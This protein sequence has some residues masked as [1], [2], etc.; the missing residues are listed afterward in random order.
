MFA[1][2]FRYVGDIHNVLNRSPTSQT[3]HQ[4]KASKPEI[5]AAFVIKLLHVILKSKI[6]KLSILKRSHLF[7]KF[8]IADL[9]ENMTK[10]DM[11][12]K[13]SRLY[14]TIIELKNTNLTKLGYL[15]LKLKKLIH[16]GIKDS[17]NEDHSRSKRGPHEC[18]H[19]EKTFRKCS[20]YLFAIQQPTCC[21]KCCWKNREV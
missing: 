9:D 3:C 15:F 8:A 4:H 14:P 17:P 10:T 7:A 2:F 13:V 5:S 20:K 12:R 1:T 21:R 11:F 16:K 19:C 18:Q 6:T